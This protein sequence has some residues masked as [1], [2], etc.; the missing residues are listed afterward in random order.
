[1]DRQHASGALV[2]GCCDVK[3]DL[4]ANPTGKPAELSGV[5]SDLPLGS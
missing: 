5:G 1:M 3:L 2:N 4:D